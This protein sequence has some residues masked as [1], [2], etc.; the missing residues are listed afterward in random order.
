[1]LYC[2]DFLCNLGKLFSHEV[3]VISQHQT[4]RILVG[5]EPHDTLE[6]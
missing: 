5:G 1:M 4:V 2:I 3:L 6:F